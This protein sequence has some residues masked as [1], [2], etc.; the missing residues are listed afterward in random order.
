V[1]DAFHLKYKELYLISKGYVLGVVN[2]W[3]GVYYWSK[4]S[5]CS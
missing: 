3:Y 1:F 2:K 4:T 5:T